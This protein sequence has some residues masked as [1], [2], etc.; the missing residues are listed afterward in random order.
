MR[1]SPSTSRQAI[2]LAATLLI[3]GALAMPTL[4]AA[5]YQANM[6]AAAPPATWTTYHHDNQRSGYDAQQPTFSSITRGWASPT[7]VDGSVYAE[8]LVSGGSVFVATENDSVY[9]LNAT[10]GAIQWQT[11]LDTPVPLSNFPCGNIDPEGI[12]GTP[13][14]DPTAGVI[15]VVALVQPS[16]QAPPSDVAR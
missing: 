5:G 14:I 16:G 9:S 7:T 10:T 6:P 4:N 8:P 12:T 15:Y 13:V 2:G 1:P 11:N 3:L